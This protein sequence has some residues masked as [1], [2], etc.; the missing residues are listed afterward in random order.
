[1]TSDDPMPETRSPSRTR[2]LARNTQSSHYLH[3]AVMA[4]SCDGELAVAIAECNLVLVKE[5]LECTD[6]LRMRGLHF[7]VCRLARDG[8]RRLN[9][10]AED[11]VVGVALR[12]ESECPLVERHRDAKSFAQRPQEATAVEGMLSRRDV[13]EV[14]R[15]EGVDWHEGRAV[16]HGELHEASTLRQVDL[17]DACLRAHLLCLSPRDDT[18]AEALLERAC[19]NLL[20]CVDTTC[21]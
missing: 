19:C 16:L 21:P 8:A 2:G 6:V 7:C 3:S 12:D 11:E 20:A 10:C 1:M 17:F 18:E 4:S 9:G 13:I 5:L 14:R 15:P